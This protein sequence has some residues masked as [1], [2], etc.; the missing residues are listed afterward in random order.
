ATT[1]G[2]DF[3][4]LLTITPSLFNDL[5]SED[6][7]YKIGLVDSSGKIKMIDKAGNTNIIT[8]RGYEHLK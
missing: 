6:T 1:N 5:K 7:L 3:E 8:P 2:E 4:L